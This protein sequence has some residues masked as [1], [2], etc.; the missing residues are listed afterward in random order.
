MRG[1]PVADLRPV[2][3]DELLVARVAGGDEFA[4]A[5]LFGRHARP[6]RAVA[7]HIIGDGVV[8]EEIVQDAMLTLWR[9]PDRFDPARGSLRTYLL[10]IVR[11]RAI[12]RVRSDGARRRRELRS[13]TDPEAVGA[14]DDP[15]IANEER[16]AVRDALDQLEPDQREAIVL[17]YYGGLTYRDTADVLGLPEGTVKARIRNGLQRLR[18]AMKTAG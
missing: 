3:D 5:Q 2:A 6:L 13:G 18:T 15:V 14:A 1:R 16:Q 10:T 8:A 12:D 17:A 4:L 9:H 7:S 11:G